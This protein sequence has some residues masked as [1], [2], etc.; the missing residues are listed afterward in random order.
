MANKVVSIDGYE[1]VDISESALLCAVVNQP[2]TVALQGSTFD[3]QLYYG[4][5]N[6]KLNYTICQIWLKIIYLKITSK[7]LRHILIYLL[8][9]DEG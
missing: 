4:V 7:K 5:S 6:Y 3:F 9:D 8:T 2:V 1:N